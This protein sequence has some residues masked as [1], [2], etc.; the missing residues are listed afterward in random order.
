MLSASTLLS[1]QD[2]VR[3][4]DRE[5]GR[6]SLHGKVSFKD[7]ENEAS[8][9]WFKKGVA[10][11]KPNAAAVKELADLWPNYRF[12][13]FGATWCDDSKDLLPKFYKTAQQ[14][15]IDKHAIE[16][17]AV[18]RDKE[19]LELEH[20]FYNIS[21]V[22]TFIIMHQH[23]EVGRIVESVSD[24]VEEEIVRILQKDTQYLKRKAAEEAAQ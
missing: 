11:Y 17:Y 4:I 8:Y 5:S 1:A 2:F 15:M 23:R 20:R 6:I 18:N 10:N 21:R 19:S 3:E 16:M 12:V 24:S 7:I 14:A 9:T 13:V 22:P